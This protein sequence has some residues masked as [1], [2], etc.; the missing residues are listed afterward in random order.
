MS[1]HLALSQAV[2]F[3]VIVIVIV[4]IM[5]FDALGGHLPVALSDT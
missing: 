2:L 3:L 1:P 5:N 4:I